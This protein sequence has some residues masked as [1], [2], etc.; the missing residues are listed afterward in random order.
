MRN[1]LPPEIVC[2]AGLVPASGDSFQTNDWIP[3]QFTA[4]MTETAVRNATPFLSVMPDVIR[5]PAAFQQTLR[6]FGMRFGYGLKYI[7]RTFLEFFT[8]VTHGMD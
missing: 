5:H 1:P 8:G 7:M 6:T 3:A 2:H 4:G